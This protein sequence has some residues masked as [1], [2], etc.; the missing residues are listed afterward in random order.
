M[1]DWYQELEKDP[2][3]LNYAKT[4]GDALIKIQRSDGF[5]PAWLSKEDLR[6][7]DILDQSPE[8]SMSVT[9]LLKVYSLTKNK[10]YKLAA[11]NAMKAVM[12]YNIT[13]GQWED[14][15][16]YWSCSR[17]GSKNLVGKN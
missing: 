5:F 6:P 15:E 17:Y 1:L 3:L 9:F 12:E 13:Q 16:T 2:R 14:F 10:N 11:L 8:T 7:L 4:Y